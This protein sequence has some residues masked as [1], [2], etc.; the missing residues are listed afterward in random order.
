MKNSIKIILILSLI[1]TVFSCKKDRTENSTP[2][3]PPT[4]NTDNYSSVAN[5]LAVN[6]PPM[7]SYNI[8]GTNGKLHNPKWNKRCNTA[9]CIHYTKLPVCNRECD[10]FVQR[11]L[12][13]K[14]YA[15]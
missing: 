11:Y 3:T 9:K 2:V 1:V 6:A 15:A 13:K 10:N 8:D 5:F 4:N 12:S 14:R 7:Q